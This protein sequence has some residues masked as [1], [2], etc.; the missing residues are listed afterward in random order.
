MHIKSLI[1]LFFILTLTA[2]GSSPKLT[3][4]E[5]KDKEVITVKVNPTLTDP[6]HPNTPIKSEAYLSLKPHER[7][8]Y[9]TDYTIHLL[10]KI[11]ECNDKLTAI[12][13]L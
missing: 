8:Q 5:V 9:L 1:A 11:K 2:C 4:I 10:G 13:K 12:R 7:E 3:T 6:C